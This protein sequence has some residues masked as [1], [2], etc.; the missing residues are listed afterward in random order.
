MFWQAVL[1]GLRVLFH[2][3]SLAAA[4]L[5]GGLML[6]PLIAVGLMMSKYPAV[7]CLSSI[8][9]LP[10]AQIFAT[11]VVTWTLSPLIFG[12]GQE[13]AWSLPWRVLA[14]N[15]GYMLRS[16]FTIGITALVASFVPVLGRIP[17]FVNT[18]IAGS[19]LITI[20]RIVMWLD[21]ALANQDMRIWPG[22]WNALGFLLL[23]GIAFALGA[24]VIG[25]AMHARQDEIERLMGQEP[26]PGPVAMTA[27][28]FLG[29]LPAFMYGAWLGQQLHHS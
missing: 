15:P 3:E 25:A 20:A 7:G 27:G 16:L 17:T 10:V 24:A 13:A 28:S 29:L 6:L 2:W 14:N 1:D 19:C 11:L 8:V 12:L 5:F 21:P 22:F 18:F 23:G 9:L 26:T 4:I